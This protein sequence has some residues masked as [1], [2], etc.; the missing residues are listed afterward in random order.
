MLHVLRRHAP[1]PGIRLILGL[2]C[3]VTI[4]AVWVAPALSVVPLVGPFHPVSLVTNGLVAPMVGPFGLVLFLGLIGWFNKDAL[5]FLWRRSPDRVLAWTLGPLAI[6][7]LAD[8][9]LIPG[10]AF[11]LA[12]DALLLTW[13]GSTVER[14]WGTRRLLWFAAIV[15]IVANLVAA[16]LLWLSPSTLSALAAPTSKAPVGAEPLGWG[17]LTVWCLM[18]GDR[19]IAL[20]NAP[21]HRFIVAFAI[22]KGLGVIFV[23]VAAAAYELA[24]IGTALLL[25]TGRWHPSR[26]RRKPRLRPV[27]DDR[28]RYHRAG[29][30]TGADLCSSDRPYDT[31]LRGAAEGSMMRSGRGS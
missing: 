9:W 31:V 8:R 15:S 27:R 18:Q 21:A 17:L 29:V 24:G 19:P 5:A 30:A 14:R 11:G 26:W 1:T 23:G 12:T 16:G 2:L 7:F 10:R 3:A 6:L 25:V 4:A 22:L 28:E 20:I 13:F